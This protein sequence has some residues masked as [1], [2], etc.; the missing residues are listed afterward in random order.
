MKKDNFEVKV[1]GLV[2]GKYRKELPSTD[3]R[4]ALK[5][6]S[7][8]QEKFKNV[9]CEVVLHRVDVSDNGKKNRKVEYKNRLGNEY[10]LETKLKKILKI[11]K[12]IDEIKEYHRTTSNLGTEEF[13]N[14]RH[15][16]EL[17]ET[18]NLSPEDCKKIFDKIQDKAI[19]RRFSKAEYDNFKDF[20][21]ELEHIKTR[22]NNLLAKCKKKR[23]NN[24]TSKAIH[25]AELADLRYKETIETLL[26]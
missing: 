25:N 17:G 12:E 5:T 4:T 20:R 14:V 26:K 6:Y 3:Y 13:N 9:N 2:Y 1:E 11:F 10:L 23:H 24:T 21:D 7:E 15:V 18:E 8:T 16:I 19:V 22:T